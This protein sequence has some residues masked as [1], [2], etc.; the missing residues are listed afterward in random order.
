MFTFEV[1]VLLMILYL[2]LFRLN[3]KYLHLSLLFHDPH[4]PPGRIQSSHVGN[5][6]WGGR[7]WGE[8]CSLNSKILLNFCRNAQVSL[9][10]FFHFNFCSSSINVPFTFRGR[11]ELGDV[12]PHNIKQLRKLNSV[13]FPVSYNDKVKHIDLR[14][15]TSEL[16]I[17]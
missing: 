17:L 10:N 16:Q 11:I 12:T 3:L 13:I 15:Y 14:N 6:E 9:K 5:W 4:P 2:F 1:K 7:R 8:V